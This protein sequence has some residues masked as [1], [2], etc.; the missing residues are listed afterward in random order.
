MMTLWCHSNDLLKC[1]MFVSHVLPFFWLLE[2]S[3]GYVPSCT[4]VGVPLSTPLAMG[5]S[6]TPEEFAFSLLFSCLVLGVRCKTLS[7]N[8]C[9]KRCRWKP[10]TATL[11][12]HGRSFWGNGGAH[13]LHRL[14]MHY[15]IQL[16]EETRVES[17]GA[18]SAKARTA[19]HFLLAV[20]SRMYN[21][22]QSTHTT[23]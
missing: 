7:C 8:A 2:S 9:T 14:G 23:L 6:S 20:I 17:P 19:S 16:S 11:L 18:E 3:Q 4:Q 12:Q 13:Y 21:C 10:P 1:Y 22:L 5:P 15:C